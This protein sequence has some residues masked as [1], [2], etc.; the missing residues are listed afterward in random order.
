M[1]DG[2]PIDRARRRR[3]R[4]RAVRAEDRRLSDYVEFQLVPASSIQFESNSCRTIDKVGEAACRG[5]NRLRLLGVSV[6]GSCRSLCRRAGI[7]FHPSRTQRQKTMPV[8]AA[9]FGSRSISTKSTSSLDCR[10]DGDQ[11]CRPFPSRTTR[12]ASR[13][14]NTSSGLQA[15]PTCWPA[16]AFAA[17]IV[18]FACRDHLRAGRLDSSVSQAKPIGEPRLP[19]VPQQSDETVGLIARRQRGP[20]RRSRCWRRRPRRAG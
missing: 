7:P 2:D 12:F 13:A 3:V 8:A 4:G 11:P 14:A 20:S 19:H 10:E 15:L 18:V 16:S 5:R 1:V 17:A 6:F 9:K